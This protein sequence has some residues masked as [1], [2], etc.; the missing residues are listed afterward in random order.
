[1]LV[2]EYNPDVAAELINAS[3]ILQFTFQQKDKDYPYVIHLP[4][5]MAAPL[6][7]PQPIDPT[8]PGPPPVLYAKGWLPCE[9]V[10]QLQEPNGLPVTVSTAKAE[11]IYCARSTFGHGLTWRSTVI[12]GTAH[13]LTFEKTDASGDY[14]IT[15]QD[16]KGNE[17]L[18]G[19]HKIVNG[20][21]PDQWENTRSPMK[22]EVDLVLVFRVDIDPKKSHVHVRHGFNGWEV[23]WETSKPDQYWQGTIPVWETYGDP[24]YG[25]TKKDFPLRLKRFFDQK[26]RKNEGY[27]MAQAGKDSFP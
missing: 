16:I 8:L 10:K 11:S 7:P 12:N 13:G 21:I 25:D 17:K 6:S 15:E 24:F 4:G 20:I 5:R 18:W 27:A 22:K 23:G 2:D 14:D 19:L 3:H 1:L 9:F 26:S